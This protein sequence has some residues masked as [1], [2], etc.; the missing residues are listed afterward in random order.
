MVPR[1]PKVTLP[2]P[3]FYLSFLVSRLGWWGNL[4]GGPPF[5]RASDTWNSPPP[6]PHPSSPH[7]GP[8]EYST[9]LF[10]PLH[11]QPPK[12][13]LKISLYICTYHW[14]LPFFR[15]LLNCY[16]Y[17]DV[18]FPP[19]YEVW[20]WAWKRRQRH[21][22]FFAIFLT[23][24]PRAHSHDGGPSLPQK[25]RNYFLRPYSETQSS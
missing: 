20:A 25:A 3:P 17:I 18:F 4:N 22:C 2:T 8:P 11:P 19:E 10:L 6:P 9:S 15:V 12:W 21:I 7:T 13:W 23:W 16:M 5:M 1:L 24:W 14:N